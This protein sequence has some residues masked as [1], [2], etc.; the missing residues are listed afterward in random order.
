[1]E[2]LTEFKDIINKVRKEYNQEK[3]P[4]I[5]LIDKFIVFCVFILIACIGYS[6]IMPRAPLNSLLAAVFLAMGEGSLAM[7]LR[8]RLTEDEFKG[9]CKTKAFVHFVLASI[10]MCTVALYYM[11]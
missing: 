4:R 10:L 7:S 8:L 1:M 3:N 5:I 9:E 11:P 2:T 6:F